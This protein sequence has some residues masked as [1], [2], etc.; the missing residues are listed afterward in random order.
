MRECGQVGGYPLGDFA[1]KSRSQSLRASTSLRSNDNVDSIVLR[2]VAISPDIVK[3]TT[4]LTSK[5]EKRPEVIARGRFYRGAQCAC[6]R[7]H[8]SCARDN[9]RLTAVISRKLGLTPLICETEPSE[10]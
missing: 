1:P 5:L 6:L 3:H 10:I 4:Q 2:V 9:F 7:A 8:V